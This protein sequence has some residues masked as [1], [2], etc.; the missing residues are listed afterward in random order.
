MGGTWIAE[1]QWLDDELIISP[2]DNI[3][4][5]DNRRFRQIDN[6]YATSLAIE[7]EAAKEAG[8][9]GFMACAMVQATMPHSKVESNEFVRT[10][11]AYTLSMLAPARIGLPYGSIPRLLIG[12]LTTQ[13]VQQ[14]SREIVLGSS[15]SRFMAELGLTATGGR[16]GSIPRLREQMARL[17]ACSISCT[18]ENDYALSLENITIADSANLWWKPQTPDQGAL[19]ESTITLSDKFF[20]EVTENPI[21]IDLRALKALK[22]SPMALDVYVWLSYRLS[23]LRTKTSIPWAV[24]QLQ[25]G[26][27]YPATPQGRRNFKKKFLQALVK[28][29]LVY[30]QARIDTD[31]YNLILKPSRIHIFR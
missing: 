17:M 27:D 23:F 16:W 25:F 11:G 19:W 1:E 5:N 8:M 7:T 20:R 22:R 30:P 28:V 18:W 3:F 21:P 31:T 10:N 24:L 4:A 12:Y 26:A 2:F 14:K 29:H 9:L 15:L 13:A 6:L